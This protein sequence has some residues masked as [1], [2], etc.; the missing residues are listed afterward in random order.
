MRTLSI[1]HTE[2]SHGWGGQEIR[3]LTEAK[4]MLDRGHRTTLI[5]PPEAPIADAAKRMG[6]PWVPLPLR[7][8]RLRELSALRQWLI[9]N[10]THVDVLNSHSSTDSWLSAVACATMR[11]PPPIVRT[12]HVSTTIRNRPTTRWLYQKAAAHIVTAG[13]ALKHQLMIENGIPAERIT[14]VPTGI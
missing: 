10:R 14:S 8:K 12:R 11:H 6:V 5:A 9:D 7:R 2:N 4:G 1:V 3:I 13:E